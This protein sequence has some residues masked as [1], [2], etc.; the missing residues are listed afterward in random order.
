MVKALNII[1]S[2][3][4]LLKGLYNMPKVTQPAGDK[5]GFKNHLSCAESSHSFV[6]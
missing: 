4:T 5:E 2:H 6:R 1:S 3:P